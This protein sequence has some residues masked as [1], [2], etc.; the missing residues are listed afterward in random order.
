MSARRADTR[1]ERGVMAL[2]TALC[3]VALLIASA[4]VVD[5]GMVRVD[6]QVDQSAADA[7]TMAGLTGMRNGTASAL[8]YHGI[9]AAIETLQRNDARF[10]GV[11]SGS[12]SWSTVAGGSVTGD[13]CATGSAYATKQCVP[14]NQ[15][16]WGRFTWT[17]TWAGEPLKVVV[18]SGFDLTTTGWQEN[19]LPAVAGDN[20][21]DAMGCHQLATIITQSRKAVMG[22]VIGAGDLT[23]SVHSVGRLKAGNGKDAPAMLLL[24][25]TG[26]PVL[27]AG[28]SGGGSHIYLEGASSSNGNSQAGTIH[29]DSDGSG[30][31]GGSNQNIFLG[32]STGGIVAFAAPLCTGNPPT[33]SG[34]TPDPSKPGLITSVAG[35]DG[36][37]GG[38]I[39]DSLSNAHGSSALTASSDS[40]GN[41]QEPSGRP[42]VTREPIDDRYLNA[43]QGIVSN[44]SSYWSVTAATVPAGAAVLSQCSPSAALNST[45]TYVFVNCPSSFKGTASFPNATTVVFSGSINPS[46]MVSM[47]SAT[48][49]YI[50]GAPGGDAIN[51]G[52]G[53]TISVHTKSPD[54]SSNVPSGTCS[55]NYSDALSG[56]EPPS[57]INRSNEAVV[58]AKSGDIKETGGLLQMCYTTLVMEGND[59]NACLNNVPNEQANGPTS[60]PC[61][62]AAGDGQLAQTGGNVDWTAPNAVDITA[63][64]SGTPNADAL[65]GWGDTN[66]PED[67][68]FWSES[69]GGSSNPTYTM[70]GGG[71]LHVV[72]VYMLPNAD[73]FK[74]TGTGVQTL[75]NAQY[76]AS[77][78][79]LNSNN[80]TIQ[81]D[82][83]PYSVVTLPAL[84]E[85]GLVR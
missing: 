57:T 80:T 29:S 27:A 37:T 49:V 60:T 70:A 73:P 62:G 65:T 78:I 79:N 13:P 36:Y 42:L 82:V 39:R 3:V 22:A 61:S 47:P 26:C 20:S 31:S 76:V 33:C 43:V 69:Y 41:W 56:G 11:T 16:S 9:C 52:N 66:G 23:T 53:A 35:Y 24:K 21:D 77:T 17:G 38:V 6:R 75:T 46:G 19:S 2:L 10:A 4:F 83:D 40:S 84:Q 59:T 58:V 67:L 71:V 12:G 15:D 45:A 50:F 54:G 64:A 14:V 32:N 81:M 72:G 8:P 34:T 48:H 44:A 30:C 7:A 1:D 25:R 63:D 18:Q 28:S 74:L 55:N 68:A 85:V 51:L 5:F